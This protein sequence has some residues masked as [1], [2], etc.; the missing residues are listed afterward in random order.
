M[1]EG[2]KEELETALKAERKGQREAETETEVERRQ[3]IRN[4]GIEEEGKLLIELDLEA[5]VGICSP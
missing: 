1:A 4:L 2:T 3:G 5:L